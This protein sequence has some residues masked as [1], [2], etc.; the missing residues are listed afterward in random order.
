MNYGIALNTGG[1]DE[2]QSECPLADQF[3]G[4]KGRKAILEID[5]SYGHDRS[6][7]GE[8]GDIS[9]IDDLLVW[10]DNLSSFCGALQDAAFV[11]VPY[12]AFLF[13][14]FDISGLPRVLDR[15]HSIFSERVVLDEN[16]E[17]S[18]ISVV[19]AG[20]GHRRDHMPCGRLSVALDR[21]PN[22]GNVFEGREIPEISYIVEFSLGDFTSVPANC[23]EGGIR[24]R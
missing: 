13:P 21:Q 18:V 14:N 16:F 22:L 7:E 15:K 23:R 4:Y 17:I 8:Y 6:G 10:V 12:C 5:R 2:F 3:R 24:W 1:L 20:S 19:L 11:G 9:H